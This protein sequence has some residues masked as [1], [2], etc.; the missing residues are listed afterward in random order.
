MIGDGC[1]CVAAETL[2]AAFNN[3]RLAFFT[4]SGPGLVVRAKSGFITPPNFRTLSNC[5]LL[6]RR[7][8]IFK[9][10]FDLCRILLESTLRR[11]LWRYYSEHEILNTIAYQKR[12]PVVA[13]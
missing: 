6:N 13:S 5:L 11:F 3:G 12:R 1:D 4:P 9:P 10:I 7:I 2:A 8:L